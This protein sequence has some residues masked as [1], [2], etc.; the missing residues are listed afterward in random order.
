VKLKAIALALFVAGACTSFAIADDGH[1][2]G[3]KPA[4]SAATT[5]GSTTTTESTTTSEASGKA[6]G[7]AKHGEKKVTLCHKAGKSGRWVKITVSKNAVKSGLKH[8]DVAPDASGK[9]PAPAPATTTTST[10]T[11]SVTTTSA[12]TTTSG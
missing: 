11:T 8:G 12:T 5:T 4:P 10:T 1:G 3:K 9:C 7:K 2:K 6:K